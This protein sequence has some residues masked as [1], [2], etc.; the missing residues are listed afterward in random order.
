MANGNGNGT[1][2]VDGQLDWSGGIDS[3]RVPTM[4]SEE[5]PTGL[6]RNQLAWL[7]NGEVRGGGVAQRTG[8]KPLVQNF[9]WPGIFQC[10]Y[11]YEPPFANPYIVAMIGGRIYR[12]RVD[13]DNSVEDLSAVFG[14]TMP[15][16]EPLGFMVQGEE[17]LVIQSGDLV[18]LPLFWDG[19]ILRRSLGF[20]GTAAGTTPDVFTITIKNIDDT[21][22][23]T[24]FPAGS[25]FSTTGGDFTLDQDFTLPAIGASAVAFIRSAYAGTPP[26]N[27]TVSFTLHGIVHTF[28]WQ[29]TAKSTT[30]G[31]STG[32]ASEL[33]AAGPMDYYMGRIW[34]A[35]GRQYCAGDIVGSQASGSPQYD[36]R[37]SI[38]K[39]TENPT[40]LAGDAF[41]VPTMAGNIRALKHPALLDT[42]LGQG[43]LY[44]FTRRQ[45]YTLN[46]PPTRAEWSTLTEPLQRVAQIDFG[47]VSDRGVVAINGDLFYQSMDGIRSLTLAVRFF[48]QWGNVPLSRP[49]NRVLQFNDR[50]LMRFASGINFDNRL[51]ETV[52][53][54]QTPV[55]V[56][57]QGIMPLDFDLLGSLGDR[58]PPAWEGIYEGLYFLQLLE[59]DFGGLQRAFSFI[60][61][62]IT[63][64]IDLWEFTTQDRWDSQVNNDGNRVT[65]Y[66][67]T[68]AYTWGDP[69]MLKKLDGLELWFDKM[70]GKVNFMVE[71]KPDQE[72]CWIPWHAWERCAAKDCREDPEAFSCPSY[73]IQP[74]CES[75]EATANLPRP[76]VQCE[77]PSARPSNQAY[78]FQIRL[79]IKGWCRLRGLR[80]Y[81]A[82]MAQE[83]YKNLVCSDMTQ[84]AA[85]APSEAPPIPP[86][87]PAPPPPTPPAPPA[88]VIS[89]TPASAITYWEE[90]NPINFHTG[91][92]AFFLANVDLNNM[93]Y[94]E[95]FNQGITAIT[96]LD[97]LVD[98]ETIVLDGNNLTTIPALP[99]TGHLTRF[100]CQS[101]Q[102][103]T[104]TNFPS[105]LTD[106]EVGDNLLTSIPT[107]PS[108]VLTLILSV[109]SFSAATVNSILGQL[110]ANGLNNGTVE[111][112]GLDT[113]ASAANI[114]ILGGRGWTVIT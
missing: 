19:T 41:I 84:F 54:L 24:I 3:G 67:E 96:G 114:A 37:D 68:P 30:G 93:G 9:K 100:S 17:F 44:I 38:L 1:R 103:T 97:L 48:D 113:S 57:H 80:I 59:A 4:A 82:P 34:Y 83:P 11:M 75:F 110:V 43:P 60:V 95:V 56:V 50:A 58:L 16:T 7:T 79:T 104:I 28:N 15:P 49:E 21:R 42:S 63:G 88:D 74:Y 6:K 5:F 20:L 31:A 102:I 45:I 108:G 29:I 40:S 73:P 99:A 112:V 90:N 91:D 32:V 77:R 71:Y 65:W 69:F 94:F 46:V 85:F 10:A 76:P 72:P 62:K 14:L 81:A 13:T 2:I 8:W 78:Q 98:T 25:L 86:P 51:W 47:T 64:N 109:N 105:T 70:L 61:S 87:P 35:F 27:M 52:G 101:N 66:L 111:L 33:P 26:V 18:T 92:L 12:I 89:W 106:I 53:P 107:L 36:F 22:V 55:G 23:G 39:T